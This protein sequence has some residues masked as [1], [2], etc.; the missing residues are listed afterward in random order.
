MLMFLATQELYYDIVIEK[1]ISVIQN[2]YTTYIASYAQNTEVL[3]LVFLAF[4][5]VILLILRGKLI[6]TMKEDIF[7]SR[8]ILNLI[9]DT[10]FEQN[11]DKVE[12]LI[13]K[14]KD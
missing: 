3:F 12:K 7:Q 11:R 8:G 1:L 4:Q 9:P 10:F 13:K 2:T 14:L 6:H 5:I